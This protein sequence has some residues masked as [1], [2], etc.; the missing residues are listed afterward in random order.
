MVPS[1]RNYTLEESNLIK[2]V[3]RRAS[4]V[5]E[6]WGYEFLNV[7][8]L[9]DWE[10]QS[11]A[12]GERVRNSIV[13]KGVE[14]VLCLRIDFTSQVVKTVSTFKD[15]EFPLRVYYFGS[16]VSSEGEEI[17][18]GLELFGVE[19]VEGDVEVICAI[20]SLLR[21][22]GIEDLTVSVG[23][24]QIVER[25]LLSVKDAGETRRA[26]L[27]K[28]LTFL[29]RRFGASP[30]AELPLLQG[31]REVLGFLDRLGF[32]DIRRQLEKTG[33]LL[34][35][36]GVSFV[37]DLSE[38]REFPY[39]TGVVFEL[40]HPSAGYP[41]AGGGR[42]D[43]LSKLFGA[44]FPATGGT[45]YV[46][47]LLELR[48][49]ERSTKE[50]FVVDTSGEKGLGF[51]VASCLREKGYRVGRDIVRRE[52]R[53]SVLYAFRAGYRRVVLIEGGG[54]VKLYRSPEE[55]S[56]ISLEELLESVE[57]L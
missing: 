13:F 43:K 12:L 41:I 16:V 38:I 14:D 57:I 9:E 22:L 36:A 11:R 23:H 18:T 7:P 27:E 37:Y 35:E 8:I 54:R 29:R 21:E 15:P 48:T 51:R 3:F 44:E 4:N 1:R 47:R 20:H 10:D 53:D 6:A 28:D 19:D 33:D 30:I 45:V 50:F 2:E 25:I 5:F 17:Q 34:S 39:Y 56:E 42:Y 49:P 46:N 40:F 24:V 55:F 31:G 26:F 52:A 32:G